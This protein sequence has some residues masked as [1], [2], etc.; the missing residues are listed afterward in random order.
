MN[1]LTYYQPGL[2][3]VN[4]MP[5]RGQQLS[6]KKDWQPH[7]REFWAADL[8]RGEKRLVEPTLAQCMFLTGA[9]CTTGVWWALQREKFRDDVMLGLLPLVP[10]RIAK[11]K[12][13]LSDFEL[14]DFVR[15]NGINR[16]F[17]VVCA[18]EAAE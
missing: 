10:P 4:A 9:G 5:V 2:A 18:V 1:K 17:D 12:A 8:Y 13:P 15:V 3:P 14:F 7:E 6:R 11:L 16:V